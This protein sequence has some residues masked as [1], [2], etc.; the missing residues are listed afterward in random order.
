MVVWLFAAAA[1]ACSNS[2]ATATNATVKFKDVETLTIKAKEG[3]CRYSGNGS[4]FFVSESGDVLTNYHV[5]DG[6]EEVVAVWQDIPYKMRVAACDKNHDLAML[7][8]IVPLSRA[9]RAVDFLVSKKTCF[10]AVSIADS[11]ICEVGDTVYVIGYPNID[12]QGLEAKVTKGIVSSLTGFKGQTDNFQMDAAIQPG[13]SGGPVIDECGRL[14]GVSVASLRGGQNVNY[15]IKIDPVR[16]FLK[17][18]VEASSVKSVNGERIRDVLRRVMPSAVLILCYESGSR[19]LR[20][21]GSERERNEARARFE[22]A[23]IYAKLLKVRKEW[24]DLKNLTESLIKE[25]G[26]GVGDDIKE[27]NEIAKKELA[28]GETNK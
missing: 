5:V 2:V 25:F 11:G 23:V 22:K 17:G 9:D 10:P 3:K 12:L 13:N 20:F 28:E 21:D 7:S 26:E 8:P 6:A 24:K 16:G 27:L 19:P 18:K 14:V 15:A 4:G 1:V